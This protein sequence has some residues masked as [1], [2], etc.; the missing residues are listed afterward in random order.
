MERKYLRTMQGI[1]I[2]KGKRK[3]L[4]IMYGQDISG[5]KIFPECKKYIKVPSIAIIHE[6]ELTQCYQR[7]HGNSSSNTSI[8]DDG[9]FD[10]EQVAKVYQD[11][12]EQKIIQATNKM[13]EDFYMKGTIENIT[14]SVETNLPVWNHYFEIIIERKL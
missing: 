9:I 2:P 10:D 1:P 14:I 7:V 8:R 3:P 12:L 6:N 11:L 4:T 5:I 13:F